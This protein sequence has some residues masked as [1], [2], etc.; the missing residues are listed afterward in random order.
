M[1]YFRSNLDDTNDED[2]EELNLSEDLSND[3]KNII[4]DSNSTYDFSESFKNTEQ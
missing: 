1:F 3:F 4:P 2:A